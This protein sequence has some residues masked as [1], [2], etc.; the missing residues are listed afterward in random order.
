MEGSI[1][2]VP[3]N[4]NVPQKDS[5]TLIIASVQTLKRNNKICG[6]KEVLRLVKQ[7]VKSKIT[8]KISEERLVALVES[9]SVKIKLLGTAACLSLLNL[10][11]DS[12]NKESSDE[13][14]GSNDTLAISENGELIKFKNSVIEEFDALKSSFF[15]EVNLFKN[16]HLSSYLNDISMNNS[17]RLIKHLQNNINFLREQL[18]NKVEIINS[19]LRQLS[20]HDDIVVRCNYEKVSSNSNVIIPYS[21]SNN[22]NGLDKTNMTVN[23]GDFSDITFVDSPHKD[24]LSISE[25]LKNI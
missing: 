17:E 10:N 8:K 19:L 9:H 15:A 16:K 18:K 22:S 2:D 23:T 20:K 24:I 3:H 7:S 11:Q 5:E 4:N 25:Q 1:Y 13:T 14:L 6:K 12:N 21:V